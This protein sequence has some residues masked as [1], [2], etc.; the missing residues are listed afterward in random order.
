[1]VA[2]S[3]PNAGMKTSRKATRRPGRDNG[4]RMRRTDVSQLAPVIRAASS[5]EGSIWRKVAL[6]LRV[7]NGMKRAT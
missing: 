6:A 1:M 2:L 4:T 5:S 7:A 3:S